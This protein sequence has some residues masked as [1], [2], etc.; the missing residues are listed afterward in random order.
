LREGDVKTNN[1]TPLSMI[2]F[3]SVDQEDEPFQVV[4]LKGTF[5]I[6]KDAKIELAE[7]QA[8]IRT[9]EEAWDKTNPS[10]LRFED[11]LAPV[12]PGTDVVVNATAFA[13]GGKPAAQ[14]HA[15][16]KVGAIKKRV[17]VTGPRVWVH[18]PLLGWSLSPIVPVRSV[19]LRYERAFGGES[20]EKNPVGVGFVNP[21][22]VDR[23]REVLAPQ[24]LLEDGRVP[25][26]GEAYPVEGLAAVAKAWLPRRARAGTFDDAWAAE[27]RPKMPVDFD[28]GYWNAAHP[29]LIGED[30][31]RGDEEVRLENLHPEHA[32]LAFQLPSL[33]VAAVMTDRNGFRYG[34]PGRLDT[35]WI[36]AEAMRVELT[37]RV[38]LPLFKHGAARLDVRMR[39]RAPVALRKAS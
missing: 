29:D 1:S 33:T 12:K 32:A 35:V 20:Y 30:F 38:T 23:S 28:V 17:L 5:T 24:I 7:A 16:I 15:G 19:P 13:P 18:V 36:D 25:V 3:R 22:Q 34:S 10:S 6:V 11:D 26:F 14:W 4:V 31:L 39:E 8:P 21:R 2:T 9:V 27:R 37:W